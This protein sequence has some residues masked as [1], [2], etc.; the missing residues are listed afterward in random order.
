MDAG[1]FLSK[2]KT[3]IPPASGWFTAFGKTLFGA[4]LIWCVAGH[5]K[6]PIIAGWSGLLGFVFLLHFGF[7]HLLALVWQSLGI[8]AEPIMNS[9]LLAKSLSEFWSLRW[10]RGFNQLV[11]QFAMRP[12]RRRFGLA[13]ATLGIFVISGLIHDLVIS[14]PA[15]A[16]YGLPSVYFVIQGC[17]VLFERS[18]V[19]K[20]LGL[21]RGWSGW[22]YT[23]VVTIS[24]LYWL[25][26]PPFI[27]NVILPF[28]KAL[29]AL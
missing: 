22:F 24:P 7:F 11:R 6:S 5:I 23:L 29:H 14:V 13:G 9:P 10:N 2:P 8:A 16:G 17:G 18:D 15:T 3:E 21:G 1:A 4:V 12:L 28:M 20:R 19:A 25:F 26:H 27:C